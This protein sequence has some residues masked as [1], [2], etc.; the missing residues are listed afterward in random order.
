MR[1]AR[2]LIPD[3]RATRRK[4]Q[5]LVWRLKTL[6]TPKRIRKRASAKY[7]H[8]R[9]AEFVHKADGEDYDVL[10][11][12]QV[13]SFKDKWLGFSSS[14]RTDQVTCRTQ[15]PSTNLQTLTT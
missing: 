9:E 10:M 4:P 1:N 15:A 7:E 5:V 3:G 13:K 2:A 11:A 8:R 6:T 14:I 12:T